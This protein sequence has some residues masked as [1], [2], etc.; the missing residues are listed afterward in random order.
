MKKIKNWMTWAAAVMFWL[1]LISIDSDSW[2]P[3]ILC[4]VSWMY[5]IYAAWR[6]GWMYDPERDETDV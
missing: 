1:S 3:L 4:M 6:K 2:T 5:L